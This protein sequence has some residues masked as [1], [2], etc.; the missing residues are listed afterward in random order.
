MSN[1]VVWIVVA[2]IVVLAG[3]WYYGVIPGMGSATPAE[4]QSAAAANTGGAQSATNAA[5]SVSAAVS[6]MAAAGNNQAQINQAQISV[7]AAIT[8][9]DTMYTSLKTAVQISAAKGNNMGKATAA[10]ENYE[11]RLASLKSAPITA[12]NSASIRANL[13]GVVAN[14]ATINAELAAAKFK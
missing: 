4:D 11:T 1:K 8:V 9:L 7:R 12:A 2:I 14:I 5:N 10:L 6:A 13:E 3:L